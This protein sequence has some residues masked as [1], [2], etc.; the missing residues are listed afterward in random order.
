[1][2]NQIKSGKDIPI[3]MRSGD[4]I[5]YAGSGRVAADGIRGWNP[6][7]DVTPNNKITKIIHETQA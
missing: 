4:E 2:D 7:F 1:V 3:E 5:F 6:V